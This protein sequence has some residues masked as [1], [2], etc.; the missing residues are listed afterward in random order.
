MMEHKDDVK[1]HAFLGMTS[2]CWGT[3]ELAREAQA[4]TAGDPF[5]GDWYVFCGY[6][7]RKIK[8]LYWEKNGFCLWQ[9]KLEQAR[10]PWP[11]K[12]RG[13][14]QLT[15]EELGLILRGINIWKEHKEIEYKKFF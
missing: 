13:I 3:H 2:M 7:R 15:R 9:K 5:N 4:E 14:R 6:M 10:F 1:I 8:I 11:I 12:E